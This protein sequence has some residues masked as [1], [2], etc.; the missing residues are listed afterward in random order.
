MYTPKVRKSY[1]A[2]M[3]KWD[4]DDAKARELLDSGM[5][6]Y[7]VAEE[8]GASPNSI[9]AML[10]HG[11]HESH[12][13]TYDREDSKSVPTEQKR[14]GTTRK[15]FDEEQFKALYAQG[16]T[17]EQAAK[18]MGW[19][20]K[21]VAARRI[22]LGLPPNGARKPFDETLY[23]TLHAQGMLDAEAA[24]VMGLTQPTVQRHRVE[25]GLPA[26]GGRGE[27]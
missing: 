27:R 9:K 19:A 17:D 13:E 15:T 25:M 26:N 4:W 10:R 21:T 14:R 2:G 23:R 24:K 7:E 8:L 5:S 20:Y 11:D 6:V 16:M 3:D 1:E 22:K 12:T 18:V